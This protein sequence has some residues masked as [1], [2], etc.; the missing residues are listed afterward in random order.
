MKKLLSIAVVCLVAAITI[1]SCTKPSTVLPGHGGK[2][3]V[4]GTV[5]SSVGSTSI[6]SHYA[7]TYSFTKTDVSVT[8]SGSTVSHT[9]AWSYNKDSKVITFTDNSTTPATTSTATVTEAKAKEEK[10]HSSETSGSFTVTA[11][12][13]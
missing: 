2:W 3:T 11:D 4:K 13:T 7:G 9:Y 8:D 5:V 12:F 10:W 1:S 6:T